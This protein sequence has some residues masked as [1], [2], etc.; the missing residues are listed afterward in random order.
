MSEMLN[1]DKKTTAPVGATIHQPFPGSTKVYVTGSR[2]D[3]RVPFREVRQSPTKNFNGEM[4]V[5]PAVRIY[6][7][8]GIYTDMDASV[9]IRQGIPTV[10]TPW[11]DERQDTESIQGRQVQ[12]R[13]NGYLSEVHES[14]ALTRDGKGRLDIFPGLQR[15]IRKAQKGK[16]VSQ[17]HYARQGMITPEMEYIAIRE[18]LGRQDYFQ[19]GYHAGNDFGASIPRIITPEFIRQEVAKGRAIIPANINHPEVEPMIIGRNFRVKINANIGNS[20]VASSIEEEVEKMTWAIRWG[21]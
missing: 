18:N 8:S 19:N 9:D 21:A 3:I 16:N 2:Q 5:N 17:M 15:P 12:P 7:P 13:D 14:S 10:R 1:T 4:E 11:I 20:A 6:D